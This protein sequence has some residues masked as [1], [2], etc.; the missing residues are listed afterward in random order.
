M[1]QPCGAIQLGLAATGQA[2]EEH[3]NSHG[4]D[5]IELLKL[6]I[7]QPHVGQADERQHHQH[8]DADPGQ[9]VR[10]VSE[11]PGP[12]VREGDGD[13]GGHGERRPGIVDGEEAEALLET[14][15]NRHIYHI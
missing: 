12:H 5:H 8:I 14:D 15:G 13:E 3:R 4:G 1:E 10:V 6:A 9:A 2:A 7:A 11:D